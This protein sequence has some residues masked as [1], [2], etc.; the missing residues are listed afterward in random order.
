MDFPLNKGR[1]FLITSLTV[2][3]IGLAASLLARFS[4]TG[5]AL[6][7]ILFLLHIPVIGLTRR[8]Q[9]AQPPASHSK[10][11]E[12]HSLSF[13]LATSVL[14]TGT[15]FL[16]WIFFFI[17]G[18]TIREALI[19]VSPVLVWAVIMAALLLVTLIKEMLTG[20]GRYFSL[21]IAG[22]L[23]PVIGYLFFFWLASQM[24]PF[25]VD[26]AYITFRYS[27]NLAAGWGPTYNPGWP[28][29]EG[30]T[31]FAWM[32]LM[33]VPH[34]LGANVA[35]FSKLAGVLLM[36]GTF[37]LASFLTY[38]LSRTFPVQARL[39]FGSFAAFL[40]AMLPITAIHAISGMETSL[41][42]FL[43]VLLVCMVTIGLLDRSPLLLWA[44]LAGLLL[45][46]TRP[47]GNLIAATLLTAG[48]AFSKAPR[49][50]RL[51]WTGSFFYILPGGCYFAW[52]A[53]YYQLAFPL[54]FYMKVLHGS[55]L[56]GAGEIGSY[57]YS[58]LPAISVLVALALLRFRREFVL[59][60]L[61]VGLLLV[62]YLF[63]VHAMGFDWRFVYPVTPLLFVITATGGLVLFSFLDQQIP[64]R[65]PWELILFGAFFLSSLGYLT[66][67]ESQIRD[68]QYYGVGITNY[69][70]FGTFLSE[71]NHDHKLTMAIGDAGTAPYYSDWQVIDL[72]GLNSREIAFGS[73]SVPSLLFEAHP[74]DLIVLSI[75]TNRNRISEEHTGA[76][77]LY[78]QAVEHGMTRI[79]TFSFGRFNYIWV[80][81][82]PDSDLS[83]Y[84]Q[85]NLSINLE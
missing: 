57:L 85:K 82:Y 75:G 47:E 72:F 16:S 19:Q 17:P 48:W 27:R 24:F 76:K 81:G 55:G 60:L 3:G 14:G 58:L 28:P 35:T 61:P 29:V 40:T 25:T 71:F 79:A 70:T 30:Y 77:L 64:K 74:V 4:I 51:V 63:P 2:S 39:F 68:K 78:Q 66:D 9:T 84:I 32:M 7:A 8:S 53:L 23:F 12:D 56:A 38:T 52:R 31:T 18:S 5:L 34:F 44:P 43:V 45:G 50:N 62:F 59:V 69:K 42:T 6:A 1:L 21:L 20:E 73:V 15:G 10:N 65:L 22:V 54:P 36:S 11:P 37:S 49:R 46:L 41:F 83:E 67:L 80:L 26:D 13:I 33:T